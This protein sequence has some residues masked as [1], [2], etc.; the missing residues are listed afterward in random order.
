M[1]DYL[2]L[3]V[4]ILIFLVFTRILKNDDIDHFDMSNEAVQ[5]VISVYN[6][7][8][9]NVTNLNLSNSLKV[10]VDG[11]DVFSVDKDGN[12]NIS[13]KLTV[14]NGSEFKGG[15]HYFSDMENA[16][17]LRIGAA[18][19]IPGL[20]SEDGKQLVLGSSAGLVYFKDTDTL[21]DSCKAH[22]F[23]NKQSWGGGYTKLIAGCDGISDW[24]SA[25]SYGNDGTWL[26][27]PWLDWN[28]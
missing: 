14:N 27:G 20:Y 2:I 7:D 3:I 24:F 18:W 11:K 22:R 5:N 21:L 17:R 10:T 26:N 8:N 1:T 4:I 28:G 23:K 6:K 13:G 15:R 12:V 16:G 25:H 19:G 9:M